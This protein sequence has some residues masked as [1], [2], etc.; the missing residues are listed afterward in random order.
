MEARRGPGTAAEGTASGGTA[1]GGTATSGA[2][3]VLRRR[4]TTELRFAEGIGQSRMARWFPD[5]LLID[6]TRTMLAPLLLLPADLRVGMV[7]LGGGSQAKFLH[8]HLPLVRIEAFEI[9][10]AVLALRRTFRVPEDD[11]R[12]CVRLGDAA[13]M[14]PLRP[15]A[16]DLLLVDGYDAHGIPPAL[17]TPAFYAAARASLRPGG[18]LAGNLY[19]TDH[20]RHAA[21]LRAAFGEDAVRLLEEPRQCNRV[22]FGLVPPGAAGRVPPRHSAAAALPRLARWQLRAEFA[23]LRAALGMT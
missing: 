2:V 19:A 3:E 10:P 1:A 9:D 7:G 15:A 13:A 16:Y 20:A 5:R 23:R 14:L 18:V 12:L 21:H 8:R 6:Y 17:S 22:A 4:W 11:A